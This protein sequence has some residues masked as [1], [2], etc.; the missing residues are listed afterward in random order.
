MPKLDEDSYECDSC[1][2]VFE[3][4]RNDIWNE[5]KA[6][7]EFYRLFPG[8]NWDKREI[9]CDDCWKFIRPN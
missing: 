1:H 9:I 8:A 7:E 4:V 2:G 5:E 3:F 6:K